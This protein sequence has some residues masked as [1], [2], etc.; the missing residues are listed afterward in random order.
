MDRELLGGVFVKS[1]AIMC[2]LV[3]CVDSVSSSGPAESDID[4]SATV[5]GTGPTVKGIDVSYYQGNINWTAVAGDGVKY[6][7]IRV[8][9]GLNTIDTKFTTYWAESRA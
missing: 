7:Q 4:Q 9:D 6:A 8:S 1:F 2:V 3:G 5:C